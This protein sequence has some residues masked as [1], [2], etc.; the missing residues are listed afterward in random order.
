MYLLRRRPLLVFA[1]A[2][3]AGVI[4]AYLTGMPALVMLA[5]AA[6]LGIAS[7]ISHF[8]AAQRRILGTTALILFYLAVCCAGGAYTSARLSA[9][10][11]FETTYDAEFSGTVA[12]DPYTDNDGARYVC[13]LTGI[14]ANGTAIDSTMRLYLRGDPEILAGIGCGM[15]IA[16]TGHIYCP[17]ES[18]NPHEFDFGDYL[19]REGMAGYITCYL[20]NIEISGES[21]GVDAFLYNIR[22]TLGRRVDAAFPKS[23]QLV[24]A[25]VLGDKRDMD[26]EI[27]EDFAAAGVAHLL[28]IS[29]LHIT[30]IAMFIS[31]LFKKLIGVWPATILTLISVVLY[32]VLIGFSPSI[33]RAAIMYAA[34]CGAPLFGRP[35]EG[36]TRLSLAFLIIL[37][38]NPG[39]IAD[40]GFVL[41][42]SASAG[43]IWLSCPM[44][45]LLQL[46]RLTSGQ[47]IAKRILR[48]IAQLF[49]ATLSAQLAT[50]PALAM[51]YGTFSVISIIS[52]LFLVPLCLTSLVAAYIGLAFPVL[53]I[54]PDTALA[55]LRYLTGLCANVSWAEIPV[56]APPV[57]LW[58]GIFV[59]GIS[60]SEVSLVPKKLK[61][62]LVISIPAMIIIAI[63]TAVTPGM[64]VIF[65]DVGQADSAVIRN[66]DS[67]YVVDLGEDGLVTADYITGENLKVEALFLSHPHSDHAG[68]LGEFAEE[69]D[70]GMIYIPAGWEDE[71]EGE[72]MPVEWA[73][74]IS[75]G[76]PYRYLS[77][78]DEIRISN[79]AV[80]SIHDCAKNT[81][82]AG[83][84]MSLIMLLDYGACEVLFTGDANAG[85]APDADILKVGHHGSRDATDET[86]MQS[87]TPDTA[88]IS[89]GRRNRYGHPAEEVLALLDEYGADIYR[90]DECGAI[91]VE[92]DKDGDYRITTFREVP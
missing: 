42:F 24:R 38:I 43:L 73:E 64:E 72:Q 46:D 23:N 63:V 53:A 71:M 52:N 70:I 66:G 84:D 55:L 40:P 17:E 90:T 86:V 12:G 22:S 57:W 51:F 2:Y 7:G 75:S 89:V 59:I 54:V 60:V 32:G 34:L 15:E 1:A 31:F 50:Y 88:I 62:W 27:R 80:I 76:V 5:I 19:W 83:N 26:D 77:G 6:A 35:A 33:S 4:T 8:F 44:M 9:R 28:A 3:G 13:E 85:A 87:V 68:G 25:L 56:S 30:L 20:D 45:R 10:P 79:D 16:G 21:S 29:G 69:C 58:L 61:P 39:N 82:D 92:L 47:T 48:Y 11:M 36:T 91:T 14:T 74:V 78:G 37:L 18:T 81:G 49:T 41:S 65:L 67:A